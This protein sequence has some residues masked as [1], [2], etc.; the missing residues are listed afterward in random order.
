MELYGNGPT[1]VEMISVP[2]HMVGL[3]IGKGGE[4]VSAIESESFCKI[5]FQPDRN[6]TGERQCRLTGTTAA[7][8]KAKELINQIMSKNQPSPVPNNAASPF[9]DG[10]QNVV[11]IMIPGNRAGLIIGKG[12]ETIKQ[13]QERAGVRMVL[14]QENNEATNIP[15]PLRISGS[16]Q[17]CERAREMVMELLNEKN[18]QVVGIS[19]YGGGRTSAEMAVP[20]SVIGAIIGK[21]GETIK[22]LQ[23][24][25]GARIQ[26][27]PEE[28]DGSPH[29]MCNISG[30]RDQISAAMDMMRE[31]MES[32]SRQDGVTGGGGRSSWGNA[33]GGSP[34]HGGHWNGHFAERAN[35]DGD[36][37]GETICI[38]PAD[39]CG[40]VIGKGGDTIREIIRLSNAHVELSR[41]TV[42]A[43][44]RPNDRHFIIQGSPNQ[45]QQALKLIADKIGMT[46]SVDG[47]M[48]QQQ[49]ATNNSMGQGA[50]NSMQMYSNAQ[51]LSQQLSQQLI[52]G[53]PQQQQ[54][55]V[56]SQVQSWQGMG[57]QQQQQQQAQ[58]QA[59]QTAQLAQL[60][61]P[62]Q[63][64]QLQQAQMQQPQL[65]MPQLQQQ[66]YKPSQA[67]KQ[68]GDANTAAWVLQSTQLYGGQAS[69][70]ATPQLA[71]QSSYNVGSIAI[72]SHQPSVNPE[73]GQVDY[74]A[75]WAEYY[76]QLGMHDQANAILQRTAPGG[77][78]LYRQ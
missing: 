21:G 11:E 10:G 56:L 30:S 8:L 75:A 7:I 78:I 44:Q 74:S 65:M 70:Q 68:V 28:T 73:T 17:A 23:Q 41:D 37:R 34:D 6:G 38:V 5:R 60:Q 15:K 31:I 20:C 48:N 33:A 55:N 77:T 61:Q 47:A 36:A 26:F 46:P 52:V 58:P 54:Q 59:Q 45:T 14:I 2:D 35:S 4:Q 42:L 9:S 76:R 51:Q 16:R 27:R 64:S 71:P 49:A 43:A 72:Q 63:L 67:G 29:R 50:S 19:D 32:S 53:G 13:L 18:K 40:L 39:K 66:L 57:Y 3:V 24:D 69:N 1:Q 62:Q 12:G 25:S 22:K